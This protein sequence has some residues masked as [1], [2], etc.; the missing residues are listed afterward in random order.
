[1]LP[2]RSHFPTQSCPLAPS[3]S[4]RF[5]HSTRSVFR[6]YRR[7]PAITS[8]PTLRLP[9]QLRVNLS[10]RNRI[11]ELPL[12]VVKNIVRF[13]ADKDRLSL[14]QL[15]DAEQRHY[16]AHELVGAK[17]TSALLPKVR[18]VSDVDGVL[19]NIETLPAKYQEPI[20]IG[21]AARIC[22]IKHSDRAAAQTLFDAHIRQCL[23]DAA[24]ADRLAGLKQEEGL[25]QLLVSKITPRRDLRS[26]AADCHIDSEALLARIEMYLIDKHARDAVA[27]GENCRKVA[28]RYGIIVTNSLVLLEYAAIENQGIHAIRLGA[29]CHDIAKRYGIHTPAGRITLQLHTVE[30][31]RGSLGQN[32]NGSALSARYGIDA[33][34]AV[35]LLE[36]YIVNDVVLEKIRPDCH[37]RQLARQYGITTPKACELIERFVLENY[38]LPNLRHGQTCKDLAKTYGIST[39][40]VLA[41]L[42]KRIV[43]HTLGAL[44]QLGF[45][46]GELAERFGITTLGARLLLE[47]YAVGGAAKEDACRGHNCNRLAAKYGITQSM[48]RQFLERYAFEALSTR[49]CN[50]RLNCEQLIKKYGI[51]TP[52]VQTAI[53][54]HKIR[55]I[56]GKALRAGLNCQGIAEKYRIATHAA[57]LS[58]Q[59]QAM[60]LCAANRLETP[61][62]LPRTLKCY[63]ITHRSVIARW[64]HDLIKSGLFETDIRAGGHCRDIAVKYGI[65]QPGS[66]VLLQH[67]IVRICAG[68]AVW[69]GMDCRRAAQRYGI[70]DTEAL[71]GLEE[72]ALER[73]AREARKTGN[74]R[75]AAKICGITTAVVLGKLIRLSIP[76]LDATLKRQ[77][78]LSPPDDPIAAV[79]S[80]PA[81]L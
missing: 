77:P 14:A 36:Q 48:P 40:N 12:L 75:R 18:T 15:L 64:E 62:N 22:E 79:A 27:T 24:L 50:K 81:P 33:P 5:Y 57:L 55:E 43:N 80:R 35:R 30:H 29:H 65:T 71:A 56:A 73:A 31:L 37:C 42:E 21:L 8:G 66:L 69:R 59:N 68:K 74:H 11:R 44:A 2:S 28:A 38:I 10:P 26:V 19:A 53:E 67:E 70:T 49:K 39:H 9:P 58:L 47:E 54:M 72:H 34:P 52:S 17:V 13:L 76:E 45:H 16:I 6:P 23:P 32:A 51:I 25:F 3:G 61:V 20:L 78:V 63:G 1:M 46:C 60:E 7:P 4:N 41:S